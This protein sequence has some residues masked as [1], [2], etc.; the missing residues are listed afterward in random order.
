MRK[1]GNKTKSISNII[2][3]P[4]PAS[5]VAQRAWRGFPMELKK[6]L[7]KNL[8]DSDSDRVPNG[9][10]CRPRNPKKQE[11]FLP[12]DANFVNNYSN[13]KLG[14]K[15]GEGNFAEVF[16]L[17]N[18]RNLVIKISKH[19][20]NTTDLTNSERKEIIRDS[21]IEIETEYKNYQKLGFDKNSLFIPTKM[22]N[23]NIGGIESIGLI[24]PKVATVFDRTIKVSAFNKAK[25]TDIL[26]NDLYKKLVTL[27]RQGYA[28]H[29]GLQLGVDSR[30]PTRLFPCAP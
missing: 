23:I 17:A 28:F 29:D 1:K 7:R 26:L 3:K 2:S 9:F 19:F 8:P 14:K 15:I 13:V 5:L 20:A 25:A 16:E 6:E 18:N 27:T 22:M 10:D 11:S 4:K 24:R 12:H 30:I 21:E